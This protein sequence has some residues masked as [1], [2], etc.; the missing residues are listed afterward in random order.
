MKALLFLFV[1][2]LPTLFYAQEID[3]RLLENHGDTIYRI[4]KQKHNYYQYLKFEMDFAYSLKSKDEV[5]VE[6]KKHALDA[7]SFKNVQGKRIEKSD[8]V[9]G[10]FNFK[11]F[12]I[13]LVTDKEL[14]IKLDNKTYLI[15]V[16]RSTL[17]EQFQKSPYYT[18]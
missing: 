12:G 2:C 9:Q 14:V 11:A 13:Q 16:S 18:K 7:N 10:V 4:H 3:A 17:G 15:F 8:V 5:N 6:Q 1:I